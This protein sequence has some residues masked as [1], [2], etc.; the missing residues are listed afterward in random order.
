MRA[1]CIDFE[2]ANSFIGSICSVGLAIIEDNKIID[3]KYWLVKPHA[4]FLYFDPFNIEINGINKR[5]IKNSPEFDSVYLRIKPFFDNAVIV[6][7]NALFDMS[8]LLHVLNLYGIK[9]PEIDYLCT[10]EI[11]KK[12]WIGLENYKLDTICKFLNY[13]FIHHHAQEDAVACAKVLLAAI[14]ENGMSSVKEL[15][16]IMGKRLEKLYESKLYLM[17]SLKRQI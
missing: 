10:Y 9:N 8:A 2:T 16:S 13:D 4:E 12:T 17:K 1:V 6:A 11:A 14:A 3:K 15:A 5:S 7:H